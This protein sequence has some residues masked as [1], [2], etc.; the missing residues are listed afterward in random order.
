MRIIQVV[1]ALTFGGAQV[2]ILDLVKKLIE[3]GHDVEVL[4]FRD[5]PIGKKL[6]DAGCPT[7]ILGESMLDLVPFWRFNRFVKKFRP[8]I[9]HSHLF[10]AT[11][12]A[13]IVRLF[14]PKVYLIT[15]VHGRESDF[16]HVCERLTSGISD[17]LT[18]PSEYLRSWYLDNIRKLPQTRTGVIYPG[19][20]IIGFERSEKKPRPVIGT[21]SRLHPVKG[22]DLLI[23][24]AA[25]L[26]QRELDFE[27]LIG[28]DGRQRS[29]LAR[30]AESL[31][32]A[33]YCRF[34]GEIDDVKGFLSQF[35]V[36]VAASRQEA[37]GIHVCEAMERGIPVVAA[38]IDGLVELVE[39][40]GTGLLFEPGN[41]DSLAQ[42]LERLIKDAVLQKSLAEAA[43]SKVI[44][45]FNRSIA[46]EKHLELYSC[47]AY[48]PRHVHFIISS[49][50]LGGGERLALSLLRAL[51]QR[52][53]Q[54]S[55]T[56]C[57]RP[58]A[59]ELRDSEIEFSSVGL[60]LAGFFF[61]MRS[62]FD[63]IRQKP[64]IISSHLNKASL[65]AGVL[66]RIARIPVVSHVHGLNRKLYYAGS[67]HLIAVSDAVRTH[68]LAQGLP[69]EKITVI[70]NAVPFL[71]AH[72]PRVPGNPLKIA[73][74][75]KLHRNKGHEWAIRAILQS[76]EVL[77]KFELHLFG[78]GP[79]RLRLQG[80]C[81]EFDKNQLVFFHGFVNDIRPH[82]EKMDLALLPSLGEGIPLSLLEAMSLGIPVIATR[83][84]GIP[85]I[86][87]DDLNGL[88]VPA[89][90]AKA[91]IDAIIKAV[92]PSDF[93]R[94]SFGALKKFSELNDYEEMV[95]ETAS[96]FAELCIK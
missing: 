95:E 30:L 17:Y 53:W 56:C 36:F 35:S 91:L 48:R 50:E 92:N 68:L 3:E 6:R 44:A 75:A 76:F 49:G 19:V 4:A 65:F 38:S 77:P 32:I 37:F 67:S 2:I 94:L 11:F 90:D 62:F 78:D 26:K 41:A 40:E 1:N 82:L 47:I 57:G 5:G 66:G 46:I 21:L 28:G 7:H 33:Q 64:D 72:Q 23:R 81:A 51:R 9:I 70:K 74:I 34:V 27:L 18:F 42:K 71:A 60:K 61:A 89:N 55:V 10:R 13:R 54:V 69:D 24:A 45:A 87:E 20:D 39:D 14:N 63:L 29:E 85:E 31:G 22:V 79:E 83:V 73:I 43:R 86:V 88:L 16:F 52:G 8:D 93:R 12:W 25:E 58:L 15:S 84:G 96:V 59:D 80:L